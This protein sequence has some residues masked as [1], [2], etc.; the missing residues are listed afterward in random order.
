MRTG[1]IE[2]EISVAPA[3]PDFSLVRGGPLYRLACRLGLVRAPLALMGTGVVL[4]V[5][6]WVPLLILSALQGLAL[7]GGATVPFFASVS[8]HV[9]FLV[10]IPL[11]FAAEAWIDPRLQNFVHQVIES[12]LVLPEELPALG[13]A[14]RTVSCLRDSIVAEA[15]LLAL[16]GAFAL[17]GVRVDLSGDISS[18][19]VA[20]SGVGGRLTPAGWWY[21][22]VALPVFQFLLCRW[23]WRI[24]MWW[25]F[26]WRLSR[27]NLQLVPIHPDLAGGLG[28]LGVAQGHFSALSFAA[29]SVLAGMFAEQMLF[30][31]ASLASLRLSVLGIV[32]IN[33]ALFVGP[34]LLF[35]PSLFA[36]KR[37]GLREYGVLAAGYTR[38][39]DV[40]W[41]RGGGPSDEPILGSADIQS[42]ADLANSFEI[43][44]KMRVVPFGLLLVASIVA[45]TLA[46]MLPLLLLAFPVDELVR[47]AVKLLLGL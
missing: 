47:R 5:V 16:V 46:P 30:A 41:V 26:L 33:L 11:F 39:F 38:D 20:G 40:K 1:V 22:V 10:A 4:A 36:V 9:R 28:F 14:V 19:R 45:A 13:A 35:G 29:T 27:L 25:A 32:L 8:T 31:G 17:A 43:I 42:L 34:L 44:R 37:R 15:I 2:G 7:G 12:R 21:A 3:R 23:C 6:T 18:W 24:V